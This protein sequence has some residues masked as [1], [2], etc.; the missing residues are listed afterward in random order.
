MTA[1]SMQAHQFAHLEVAARRSTSS[2]DDHLTGAVVGDLAAAVDLHHG[3]ADVAE[4]VFRLAAL[5]PG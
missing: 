3:D 1:C 2:V 5:A 4:Q